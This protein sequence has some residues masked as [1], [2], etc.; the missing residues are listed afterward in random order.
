MFGVYPILLFVVSPKME[1]IST[2]LRGPNQGQVEIT[3]RSSG[4]NSGLPPRVSLVKYWLSKDHVLYNV[5]SESIVA[6]VDTHFCYSGFTVRIL[7]VKRMK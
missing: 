3:S 2:S 1:L 7:Y 5:S 6:Y 4:L